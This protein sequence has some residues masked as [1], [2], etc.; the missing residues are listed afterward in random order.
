MSPVDIE[1][2][3]IATSGDNNQMGSNHLASSFVAIV[4]RL[5][6]FGAELTTLSFDYVGNL[7]V[8]SCEIPINRIC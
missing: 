4:Y 1:S 6:P 7:S 3:P 5:D 8:D 2:L